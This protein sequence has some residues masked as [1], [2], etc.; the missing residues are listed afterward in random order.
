[1][2]ISIYFVRHHCVCVFGEF[3]FLYCYGKHAIR[4]AIIRWITFNHT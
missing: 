3:L 4:V 1:M 2:S